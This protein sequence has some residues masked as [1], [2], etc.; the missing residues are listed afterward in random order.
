MHNYSQYFKVFL[1]FLYYNEQLLLAYKFL[2][3]LFWHDVWLTNSRHERCF[4]VN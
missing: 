2:A 1:V 3:I 4:R